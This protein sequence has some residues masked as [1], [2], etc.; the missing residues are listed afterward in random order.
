MRNERRQHNDRRAAACAPD[1]RPAAA[2]LWGISPLPPTGV[3]GF[4]EQSRLLASGL[5]IAA[6]AQGSMVLLI[7]AVLAATGRAGAIA[8]TALPPLI[9][10][11]ATLIAVPIQKREPTSD[12]SFRIRYSAMAALAFV[13]GMGWGSTAIFPGP[14]GGLLAVAGGAL[15]LLSLSPL[16][17]AALAAAAGLGLAMIARG[18]DFAAVAA[19]GTAVAAIALMLPARMRI[20]LATAARAADSEASWQ[21]ASGLLADFEESGRGWFWETDAGGRLTYVSPQLAVQIGQV[22]E[23]L[24]GRPLTDL[25]ADESATEQKSPRGERT[26]GFHLSARFA[27][28]DAVVRA[29]GSRNERWWSLSGRPASDE[30]GNFIG[31]RGNGTDLTEM[32][33]SEAEVTWLARF[34]SLTG[35]PNRAQMRQTLEMALRDAR[36]GG[37]GCA[38]MLLDLDRFKSVNDTLGHPVGDTLLRQVSERIL[39]AIGEGGRVGRLGGDEFKVVIPGTNDRAH[40]GVIADE[41]IARISAPYIIEGHTVSIGGSIGVAVA[42][43]DGDCP[44]QL[45]R[46]ADL[47]LY[48]AKADGKGVFRFYEPE[49]HSSARDRRLLEMD[50]RNALSEGT[51]LHLRFQ[52]IVKADGGA[53]VGFE[54]LSRWTHPTRGEVSPSLFIPIAEEIGLISQIGEWVIRNACQEAAAWPDPVKVAV[55]ISPIQFAN[56]SLPTIVLRALADSQLPP[57]R[58]ELE[59]TEGVFLT[60][61]AASEAMFARLAAIG[62]RFSLDDFGTGYSSLGYLKRA[63]FNKIKIDQSFV[64]GAAIPGNRNAAIIRAIVT[65]AESLGMETT[66]EGA[67][68]HDELELIRSLGCSQVQGYIFGRPMLPE[69]ARALFVGGGVIEAA[70]FASARPP[71]IAVLRSALLWCGDKRQM[72]RIRNVSEGGAMAE[73]DQDVPVGCAV[74][75]A[76]PGGDSV[77]GEVRWSEAGRFGIQ[78]NENVSIVHLTQA[79]VAGRNIRVA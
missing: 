5:R 23:D 45:V 78:F 31:F 74:E 69:D 37:T 44:D 63:P 65:L 75:L 57:H 1:R 52:P 14:F 60:N 41:V 26:V 46:N 72:V 38:L 13:A 53:I 61:S 2:M 71:R 77:K 36:P 32:R 34:D 29:A 15:L 40:I 30:N 3:G 59:I 7:T 47:A 20:R 12:H 21:K 6:A 68:T 64:R 58:L 43:T 48:A 28:A 16:P 79:R 24:I 10:I 66:A 76:F 4:L 18:Q 35:L 33:K 9:A 11:A 8:E 42:P 27:F 55:N 17:L 73:T 50:L 25:F 70:G 56:P 54:A 49:M 22:S 19:S 62:V 51:G 67:E 39:S